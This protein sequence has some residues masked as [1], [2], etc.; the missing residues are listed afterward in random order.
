MEVGN[1][2]E[3]IILWWGQSP[4]STRP[5]H[6]SQHLR[7]WIVQF[8]PAAEI[9]GF[10]ISAIQTLADALSVH[11]TS[12]SW[13]Q[14]F[15]L[16]LVASKKLSNPT[17]GQLFCDMLSDLVQLSNQCE[18]T[19]DWVSGAPLEELPLVEQ[20]PI[21]HRLDHSVHTARLWADT[22]TKRLA[23]NWSVSSFFMITHTDITNCIQQ[24]NELKLADHSVEI[25]KGGLQQHTNVCANM[26][27][28]LVSEVQENIKKLKVHKR[29]YLLS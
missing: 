18:K 11:V 7:E 3:H 14:N 28:K 27:A 8:L 4:L 13:D 6:S 1:C 29:T 24:L 15:R 23:N 9:P 19:N 21:L 22:E 2:L 17:T 26:R 5:P 12:T 16:A 25:G 10:I 20:I